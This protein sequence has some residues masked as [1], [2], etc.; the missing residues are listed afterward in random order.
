MIWRWLGVVINSRAGPGPSLPRP[1]CSPAQPAGPATCGSQ[2]G[3][4]RGCWPW[5]CRP[6]PLVARWSWH[7]VRHRGRQAPLRRSRLQPVQSG[8]GRLCG[9]ADLLPAGNDHCGWRPAMHRALLDDSGGD[10]FR[11][12][13]PAGSPWTPSPAPPWTASKTEARP[14]RDAERPGQQHRCSAACRPRLGMGQPGVSRRR[15]S[16]C[17]RRSHLLADSGGDAGRAGGIASLF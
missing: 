14:E 16:G 3:G 11:E 9:A 6:W 2:R 8:H 13:P 4:D 15:D 17:C 5:R 10:V 1:P 12:A 7:G